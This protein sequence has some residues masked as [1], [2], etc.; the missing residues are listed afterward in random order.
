M[1]DVHIGQTYDMLHVDFFN[2][3]YQKS[4]NEKMTLANKTH[5]YVLS[6]F[7]FFTTVIITFNNVCC[8]DEDQQIN[9]S[10]GSIL[11]NQSLVIDELQFCMN[12]GF[13]ISFDVDR[14][15]KMC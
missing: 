8:L 11:V 1:N 5:G 6:F 2:S 10:F 7:L 15:F 14:Y 12:G 9:D 4:N 3:I 13:E